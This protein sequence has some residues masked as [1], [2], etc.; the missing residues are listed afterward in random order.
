LAGGLGA[1][2]GYVQEIDILNETWTGGNEVTH[3]LLDIWAVL[4]GVPLGGH[5]DANV[6][7]T[8]A[9]DVETGKELVC[10]WVDDTIPGLVGY[11]AAGAGLASWWW[12][13]HLVEHLQAIVLLFDH[14]CPS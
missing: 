3:S 9:A 13:G 10:F 11:N 4:E 8:A 12:A 7:R 6:P 14:L 1:D 2:G 5:E